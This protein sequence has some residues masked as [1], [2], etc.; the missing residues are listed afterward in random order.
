M[1]FQP[2]QLKPEEIKLEVEKLPETVEKVEEL[3]ETPEALSEFQEKTIEEI[4]KT[5]QETIT[6]GIEQVE[7]ATISIGGGPEDIEAG[8]SAL[9]PVQEQISELATETQKEVEETVEREARVGLRDIYTPEQLAELRA[10]TK[11]DYGDSLVNKA[12]EGAKTLEEHEEAQERAYK[13]LE[14]KI[15]AGVVKPD[16]IYSDM[17]NR[18]ELRDKPEVTIESVEQIAEQIATELKELTE[19]GF[20]KED[21]VRLIQQEAEKFAGIYAEAF[22]DA[23]PQQIFELTRDNAR[24]LAYQTERDKHVFSGS[25]H[26]TRHILEGNMRMAD[27]MI[28]SLGDKVSAK[29]KV[30]IHQII[31]DHDLGYTLGVAQAKESFAASKDHPLFSAKFVEANQEYYKQMFGKDGY[32][33]IKEGI[34][35]HSYV[36]SEYGT[37]TDLEKGFNPDIIRS[38]T[39]TVDALGVTA[40]IKCP[41][42]FRSPEVISVLQKVKLYAE[43]HKGEVSPEALAMYKDELRKIANKEPNK[44]RREGFY[45]A[46]ENQFNPVTVEMTLGQYTGVLKD[47]KITEQEGKMVP[48]IKMDISRAQALLGDL[49]GDKM[50]TKA[51]V[52]AMEDFGVSKEKIADMA[53]VIRQIRETPTEEEKRTLM[54]KLKYSSKKAVFEFAPEFAE[55]TPE[56]EKSFEEFERLSIRNEIRDLARKLESPEA[57]TPENIGT[58]LEEFNTATSEQIDEEDLDKIREIEEKIRAAAGDPEAM[59]RALA[60]FNTFA[61][62]REKEFMGISNLKLNQ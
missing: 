60:E 14:E 22:P 25:D 52:K 1:P 37:S 56:I 45:N 4:K 62:K 57:Q 21:E 24:K 34:L 5:S 3:P 23:N 38:I 9:T 19:K 26:G 59:K 44:T 51:F 6:S 18:L 27:K 49:F 39:S 10:K 36:K 47:I 50:S 20:I 46:I 11:E 13:A 41:A 33:M 29:D 28:E 53:K 2:E 54:E 40:E 58:F 31:I 7:K 16:S 42:F 35:Q 17:L 12:H 32:E 48:H 55:V 8:K 61:T 15:E 30:L 43:T